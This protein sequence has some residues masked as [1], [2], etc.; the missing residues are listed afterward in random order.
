MSDVGEKMLLELR[1]IREA[2]EGSQPLGFV[3]RWGRLISLSVT[4]TSVAK[5]ASG[6]HVTSKKVKTSLSV[7][8]T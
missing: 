5:P 1:R 4:M 3:K 7:N 8:V 6:I 2:L